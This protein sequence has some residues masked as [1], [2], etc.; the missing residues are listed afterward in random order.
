MSRSAF[1]L[2]HE[3]KTSVD[4]GFLIPVQCDEVLPGDTFNQ[5]STALARVAPLQHP[6]MHRV[7]L[8]M[9]TFYVPNRVLHNAIVKQGDLGASGDWEDIITGADDTTEIPFYLTSGADPVLDYMG[10]PPKV[11]IEVQGYPIAAYNMI[12][13]H[14]YRDQH[15]QI[16]QSLFN[17]GLNRCAWQK[18]YFTVA[19]PDTQQGDPVPIPITGS[20]QTKIESFQNDLLTNENLNMQVTADQHLFG[21]DSAATVS[22]FGAQLAEANISIDDLRRS[23]GLQRF[24]EARMRYGERY[25]DYLRYLG[26]NPS[27]GRLDRPEYLGGGKE[28]LNFSEVLS[29]A[30]TTESKT[31]DMYGHGI[32]MGRTNGFSKTFEEHGWVLT[33][34]SA[35]PKTVYQNA[36]PK[37]FTR[38]TGMDYWQ[39][40][41]EVLPWQEVTEQEVHVD[42]LAE[43]V[44][45][46]VP[47]YEE[48]RHGCSHV[49]AT[50]RGGTENDWHMA[51]EFDTPPALNG[52]FIE[53][54]PT[55]RIYQDS[56]M[57]DL[58][59]NIMHSINA[60]RFV[61]QTASMGVDL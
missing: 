50:M 17:T 5:R 26:V 32:G 18:D 58:V 53:C 3:H 38:R 7:E 49:S 23:I 42:G 57:P 47:R 21:T 44:F 1:D 45:G 36:L 46:Y 16:E 41:L 2:S 61:G 48:Y 24:A 6:L 37:K 25:V 51:R 12:Y 10:I 27:D 34:L 15:L 14:F 30:D 11:G 54:T 59:L 43:N 31:G 60:R 39:K 33:L 29:T 40:E 19:R 55:E 56:N 13:N 8:R 20:S 28:I 52:S 4:M 35:R 9:H 22:L